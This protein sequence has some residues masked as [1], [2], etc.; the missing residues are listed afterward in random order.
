MHNKNYVYCDFKLENIM[1]SQSKPKKGQKNLKIIDFGSMIDNS[2]NINGCEISTL[3]YSPP[4][5]LNSNLKQ[6][7]YLY[8]YDNYTLAIGFYYLLVYDGNIFQK[9]RAMNNGQITVDELR[10]Y[11]KSNIL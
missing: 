11:I 1:L 5:F 6:S 8:K 7:K 2:E 3:E 10:N 4:E 9:N